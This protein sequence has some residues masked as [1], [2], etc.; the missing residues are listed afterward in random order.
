MP[1]ARRM[2]RRRRVA[3]VAVGSAVMA[4]TAGAVSHHQQ[5]KWAAQDADTQQQAYDDQGQ[6]D[7]EQVYAPPPEQVEAPAPAEDLTAKLQELAQ[8]HES[9]ALTDEEFAAAKQKLL[10]N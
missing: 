3:R 9:G 5:K 6:Y 8:L 1:R 7:Q 2:M 4:G 10:A